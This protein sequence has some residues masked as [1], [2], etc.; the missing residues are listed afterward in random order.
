M[1]NFSS[2][3][4]KFIVRLTFNTILIVSK[5]ASQPWY[6]PVVNTVNLRPCSLLSDLA[7]KYNP[8]VGAHLD[9]NSLMVSSVE[10]QLTLS[11]KLI[12]V[13]RYVLWI[14]DQYLSISLENNKGEKPSWYIFIVW[15]S[16]FFYI[17]LV[18]FR[19]EDGRGK[20]NFPNTSASEC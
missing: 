9:S 8:D 15:I 10:H 19:F 5:A 17:I 6:K 18:Y 3:L 11:M 16:V 20:N 1:I 2:F 7:L 4:P 13:Y 14:R 12:W